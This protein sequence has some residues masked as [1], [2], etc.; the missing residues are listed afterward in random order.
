MPD[1]DD[2]PAVGQREYRAK[3]GQ[4]DS[5]GSPPLIYQGSPQQNRKKRLYF[6]ALCPWVGSVKS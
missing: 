5:A 2:F 6:N 4:Q 3:A 1:V